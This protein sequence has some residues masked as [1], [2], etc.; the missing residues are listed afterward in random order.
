MHTPIYHY[1]CCQLLVT[2]LFH[3]LREWEILLA[4]MMKLS[5]KVIR[6]KKVFFSKKKFWISSWYGVLDLKDKT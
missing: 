2:F 6:I 1:A 4:E 3:L 5:E